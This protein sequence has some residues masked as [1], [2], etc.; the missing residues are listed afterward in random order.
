MTN[1][2]VLISEW[3]CLPKDALVEKLV[4]EKDIEELTSL[5]LKLYDKCKEIKNFPGGEFY[6]RRKP[7]GSSNFSSLEERLADDVYELMNCLDTGIVTSEIKSMIKP[8][9]T[10]T[11][12]G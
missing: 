6:C 4:E 5:K 7:K 9:S 11:E 2:S 10:I 8:V 1:L 12:V 3:Q